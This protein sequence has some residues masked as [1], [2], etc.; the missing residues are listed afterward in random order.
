MHVFDVSPKNVLFLR[1]NN[2][3]VV[4]GT[5]EVRKIGKSFQP[6]VLSIV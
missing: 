6:A 1:R 3:K 5:K 4:P 2:I